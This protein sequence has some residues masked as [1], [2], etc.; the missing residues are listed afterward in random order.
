VRDQEYYN[1]VGAGLAFGVVLMF[2]LWAGVASTA[3]ASA[4]SPVGADPPA[5]MYLT[6]QLNP[7][8]GWPQYSPANFSV[9]SGLVVFTIVNYDV[10]ANWS[11][12]PCNVTGTV[13]DTETVN[14]TTYA[15]VPSS[16]VAHTFDIPALGLN[17]LVPGMSTVTFALDLTQ[18]GTYT[19]ICEMPCGADGF[20]G[21]PMGLPGY[22][23]GT[24]TVGGADAS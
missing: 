16:N 1:L 2:V 11:G 3:N 22:M 18:P 5:N 4:A 9:P 13:G 15:E 21:P 17:V 24:I 19:W 8:T 7:V 10:P 12:C 23:T 14:A 6:I 20:S